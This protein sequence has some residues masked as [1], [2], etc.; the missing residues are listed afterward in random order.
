MIVVAG[1]ALVD[2][3]D[4]GDGSFRAI[5]GGSPA[6]VAVGLARLGAPVQMLTRLSRDGFGRRI[7]AH[8]AGSGVGLDLAVEA[9]EPTPL[10]VAT[11]DMQGRASYSFY[12]QGTADRMWQAAEVPERL[13]TGS[14]ALCVG[15]LALALEPGA[16]LLGGLLERERQRAEVTVV[17]DPNVRPALMGDPDAA[18]ARTRR[19]VV[20]SDVVKVSDEDLAWLAPGEDPQAAARAWVATGPQLVVVTRGAAGAYAVTAAGVEVAVPAAAVTL[21]DTVGAGDAF[22][23]GLV[24]G[25]RRE[26]ALG[27]Q[28]R[29][30][31]GELDAE[32]LGS[33]LARAIRVS[34]LTCGRRGADPPYAAEVDSG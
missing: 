30:W 5:P 29:S 24:D 4:E 16:G 34:A 22:T 15:S 11:L 8:L 25:L 12:V 33:V 3:V 26:G 2:L 13:P 10:A 6:N 27:G 23:S 31:L 32:V 14:Q 18:R 17:L 9:A 20:A 1:E 7:G 28:A 19:L 21:V